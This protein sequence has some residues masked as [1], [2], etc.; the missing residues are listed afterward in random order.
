MS[1]LSRN[2]LINRTFE[3]SIGEPWDF[4]SSAGENILVG[5]ISALSPENFGEWLLL[6]VKPF[7]YKEAEI[8][9]VLGINRYKTN[10]V[11][12]ANLMA[13]KKVTLN[14]MFPKD[15]HAITESQVWKELK[16][17]SKLSFLVGSINKV[18]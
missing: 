7:K 16:N 18:V 9:Q 13:G 6:E 14:F 4:E 10:Q 15:G 12:F 11:L 2:S 17:N 1:S 3:A 8:R 5:T